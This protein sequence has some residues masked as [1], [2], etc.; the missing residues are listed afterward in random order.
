[1]IVGMYIIYIS[2][3]YSYIDDPVMAYKFDWALTIF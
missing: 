3:K 2:C 1:M